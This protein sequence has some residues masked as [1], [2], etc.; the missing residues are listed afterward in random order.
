MDSSRRTHPARDQ[1]LQPVADGAVN[2]GEA[3][4]GEADAVRLQGGHGVEPDPLGGSNSGRPLKLLST[5][6]AT[7][8]A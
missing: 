8:L 4:P 1:R 7:S 5:A 3:G 2:V 6:L